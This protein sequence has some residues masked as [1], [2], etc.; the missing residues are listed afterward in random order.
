[1]K[2]RHKILGGAS[3]LLLAT[4]VVAHHVPVPLSHVM[5][6]EILRE[7]VF[8]TDAGL[9]GVPPYVHGDAEI[10]HHQP[11]SLSDGDT[12]EVKHAG[13]IETVVFESADFA[14]IGAAEIEEVLDVLSAKS[15][16]IEAYDTNGYAVVRGTQGGELAAL[17]LR[18]VVGSALGQMNIQGGPAQLG[19]ND[20]V[21]EVSVPGDAV[22]H[23]QANHR[24]LVLMSL[25]EGQFQ[26]GGATV[27][28][29]LDAVTRAGAQAALQGLLPGF[30][31]RLDDGGDAQAK[32]EGEL[33]VDAFGASF[34][35]KMYFAFVVLEPG[36][37]HV[38]FV[39]TRFT[40][41]VQ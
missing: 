21:L 32:V 5:G 25:T 26:L 1:M 12:V 31:G 11:I 33:L 13:Q 19:S 28:L 36:S 38:E 41:D 9:F 7:V 3:A 16:L 39:S 2:T 4:V 29:G 22:G 30:F 37:L 40:V 27:P 15:T 23:A 20:L 8:L 35:D 18:D 17:S 10:E 14:D 24:Y 6:N 34:P